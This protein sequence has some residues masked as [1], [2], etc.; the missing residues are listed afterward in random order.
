MIK[1]SQH[2]PDS[3]KFKCKL[4]K[5]GF[6]LKN[7]VVHC[8]KCLPVFSSTPLND[9]REVIMYLG[10]WQKHFADIQWVTDRNLGACTHA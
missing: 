7:I 5:G 4:D 10:F 9:G 2:L 8:I 3:V 1:L 6:Y